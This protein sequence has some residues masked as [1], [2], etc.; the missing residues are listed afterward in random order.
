MMQG[1]RIENTDRA[2]LARVGSRIASCLKAAMKMFPAAVALLALPMVC[3]PRMMQ[4]QTPATAWGYM[5]GSQ[6]VEADDSATVPGGRQGAATWTDQTGNLWLFGGYGDDSAGTLGYLS[7]LWEYSPTGDTWTLKSANGTL[8]VPGVGLCNAGN[9]TS[10]SYVV[11]G[12]GWAATWVDKSGN[13]WLFGGDGC[14]GGSTAVGFLNDLWMYNIASGKWTFEGGDQITDQNGSYGLQYASST[15]YLPGARTTPVAWTGADGSFWLFGGFGVDSNGATGYLN[16]L[17][18]FDPTTLEWAWISGGL[19]NAQDGNYGTVGQADA[20]NVPG[21]RSFAMG[22]VDSKGNLWLFGGE[23]C[24]TSCAPM[25]LL[26]DV[27]MYSPTVLE[28]TW[29]AGGQGENQPVNAGTEY[30]TASSNDPGSR[31]SSFFWS[32]AAGNLWLFGGDDFGVSDRND[33]WE[34]D[35]TTME[36]TW[37]GGTLTGVGAQTPIYGTEG[38]PAVINIPGGRQAFTAWNTLDG[39]FWLFGGYGYNAPASLGNLND[40][41]EAVPAVPTPDFSL[42]AG[43]YQNPQILTITD[44][45]SGAAIYY[46]T[47]GSTPTVSPSDAYNG[48]ITL[49]GT[50]NVQAIAVAAGRGQSLPREALYAIGAQGAI[51]WVN[52][53]PITYGTALSSIQLDATTSI[54]G[55]FVYTP[56]A[57]TILTAGS[58]TLSVTFTPTN[59]GTAGFQQATATVTIQVNQAT[60]TIT[61]AT[62]AAITYGTSLG[63]TQLDATAA[64]NGNAVTGIFVYSPAAGAILPV[65]TQTLTVTFTPTDTTDYTTATGSV[66][67]VVNQATPVITWPTPA[68]IPYGT[69]LS[70]TQ[71]DASSLVAGTF[72]YAPAS[73]TLLTAGSHT[74]NVTFTPTDTTDYTTAMASVTLVVTQAT[75]TIVWPTPAPI[76]A[77]TALSSTQLDAT[78]QSNGASVA[79]TFTYL[80]PAGTVLTAGPHTLTVSF[81]PTDN[82][83]YTAATGS[84]TINVT[85]NTPSISWTQPAAIAF[86]TPLGSTQLD[87]T[88]VSGTT[89]V[90]GTFVYSPAAGTILPAGTQTLS[91]TFIPTDSVDY[92]S[93]SA[94]TTIVVNQA[95]PVL[96]WQTPAPIDYGTPLSA[97]QLNATAT[98]PGVFVY[99]PLAGTVLPV[100]TQTLSVTFTPTDNIDYATANAGVTLVVQAPGFTLSGTP[101][102]QTVFAGYGTDFIITVAPANGTFNN[103]VALTVTGLPSGA[104]ATFTPTSVTPGAASATSVL[105]INVAANTTKNQ[106]PAS[107]F[108]SGSRGLVP[109]MALLLLLPFRRVRRWGKKISLVLILAISLGAMLSLSA[110]G[111]PATSKVQWQDTFVLTVTGTSGTNTQSTQVVMT[112]E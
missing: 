108:G 59:P 18:R 42:P 95:N 85:G 6:N 76:A 35:T 17:W 54:P 55:S 43:T 81:T 22:A 58:H 11:G 88:A 52:P 72:V 26:N 28:W 12:R 4:A 74:L 93:A 9:Y 94:T 90:P 96:N 110:C 29:E 2:S 36:W 37:A 40:L 104:T 16:D 33:L 86:G 106:R 14:G 75:P 80:P 32:D 61:W 34:F 57:G 30:V 67:L 24:D 48:P 102:G 46:T 111:T 89:T 45:L 41:W 65:G 8:T 99:T 73:G 68:S 21:S 87:A 51:T 25:G 60:P 15:S 70:S 78:A 50:E 77:G 66:T 53:A 100:G 103:P 92:S 56:D 20:T 5:S 44:A 64:F 10:G 13:L 38:T 97:T 39:N 69:A 109:L 107:P 84:V 82:I 49:T 7:D 3:A 101:G 71:L 31:E 79:G 47:N 91:V 105:S 1:S 23:G 112:V 63:A 27:W 62:P 19:L 98:I 83:D